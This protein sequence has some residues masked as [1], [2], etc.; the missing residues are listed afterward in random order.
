MINFKKQKFTCCVLG[1]GY[2]GLPTAA[3]IAKTK[4][5]VIGVDIKNEVVNIVNNG[6]VH[7]IEKGLQSLV[8]TVVKEG[9]LFAKNKPSKADVFILAVP[10]PL[11]ESRKSLPKPNID[12]VLKA[13]ISI[14]EI[15]QPGNLV[16]LESTSPVGTTEK[17]AKLIYEKS[18]LEKD[19]LSIAYCPERVLPGKALEEI[20]SNN[21]VIGGIDEKS[22]L[23]GENF[24]KSF[25]KG[26]IIKTDSRTAELVKLT[27][28]AYRDVNIAFAN[29]ISMVSSQLKVKYQEVINI[30]NQH[31]RVNILKPGCGVGGHC[32]AIDPWFI[33]SQSPDFTTLIQ[34]G[35]K[36]NLKKT[37]WSINLIIQ[38]IEEL[39]IKLRKKPLVGIFGLT[40]KSDID[41]VRESPALFITEKLIEQGNDLIICEPNIKSYKNLVFGNGDEIIE[42]ADLLILLVS[43]YQFKNLNFKNKET[44]NLCGFN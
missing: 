33:A 9:Y 2:I 20:I 25:C 31:P 27:E 13:A 7:I 43:H 30:A 44:I 6:N 36:V 8:K 42:K 26:E 41:D 29:E 16:I 10:T 37:N 4:N 34:A 32:I 14:S 12:Y 35:R 38:K 5:K 1:L 18:G 28:N 21:R 23:I 24:Y 15:L 3:L 17:I 39:K 40:F 19:K 22:A 11:E